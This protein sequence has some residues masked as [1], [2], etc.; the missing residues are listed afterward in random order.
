MISRVLLLLFFLTP[1]PCFSQAMDR[2]GILVLAH[3]G[4]RQWNEAV[5]EAVAPLEAF[6]PVTVAFGM[7]QRN[8]LQAGVE[9]LEK[10]GVSRIA[11]VGLFISPHSFRHQTEYL[12]GLRADPPE[13]FLG[14]HA[15]EHRQG[16]SGD[17]EDRE[18]QNDI[19]LPIQTRAKLILNRRGLYD[20]PRVGEI[21]VERVQA[22]S[23]APEKESVLILAHGAGADAENERWLAR[24]EKLAN[25]VRRWNSFRAVQVETLRED[26]EEKR[27]AAEKRIRDFVSLGNHD[28]GRVIV[29]PFRLFGFGPY[30]DVLEGLPYEAVEMGLLPHP[31]VGEWIKEE[32]ADCFSRAGWYQAFPSAQV[33]ASREKPLPQGGSN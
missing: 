8:S 13:E 20:S 29:V 14:P 22:G 18:H 7:A 30:R 26:W 25:Q 19:P 10:A 2:V 1:V 15:H 5:E 23:V 32:A 9:E 33:P 17:L 11:V 3:G 24:M 31:N 28:G 16:S 21:L 12:L 27:K 4:T 6:C